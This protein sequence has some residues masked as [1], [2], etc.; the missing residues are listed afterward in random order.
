MAAHTQNRDT[1]VTRCAR[2]TSTAEPYINTNEEQSRLF[3][4]IV[5]ILT[6]RLHE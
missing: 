1:C 3:E 4:G 5:E 6:I 2:H